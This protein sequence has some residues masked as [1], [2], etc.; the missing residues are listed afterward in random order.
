MSAHGDAHG[1]DG[2]RTLDEV[3]TPPGAT[4]HLD[5]T[6][7]PHSPASDDVRLSASDVTTEGVMAARVDIEQRERAL[8]EEQAPARRGSPHHP[9]DDPAAA[10]TDDVPGRG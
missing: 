7:G 1:T 10:E 4:P 6:V 5:E 2:D 8:E 9:P 3:R